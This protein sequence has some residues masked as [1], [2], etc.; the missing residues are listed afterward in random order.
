MRIRPIGLSISPWYGSSY[1]SGNVASIEADA[2]DIFCRDPSQIAMLAACFVTDFV[3]DFG[4]DQGCQSFWAVTRPSSHPE[5]TRSA[6]D[7][8]YGASNFMLNVLNGHERR[9]TYC[10]VA[11]LVN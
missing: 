4:P 3:T 5:R 11:G 2:G 8:V 6:C 7:H 9:T 1:G 10:V